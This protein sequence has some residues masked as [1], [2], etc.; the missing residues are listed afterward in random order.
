MRPWLLVACLAGCA[1]ETLP[2]E[3]FSVTVSGVTDNCHA[4]FVE[5]Q[6]SF[7]Y[8]LVDDA[9]GSYAIYIENELL[10]AGTLTGCDFT[11]GSLVFTDERED[12]AYIRWSIVGEARIAIGGSVSCE[13]VGGG[14][15][16][17]EIVQINESTD[18]EVPTGCT[19]I[20]ETEGTWLGTSR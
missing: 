2:G 6:E 11:Y 5:Y 3:L 20:T 9:T 1:E 4:E 16:G 19:Y 18:P 13:D 10:G 8:R 7:E 12:G 17:E 15:V 14:W